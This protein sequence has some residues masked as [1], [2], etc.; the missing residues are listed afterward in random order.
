MKFNIITFG[1]K[2][3][4]YESN[5]MKETMLHHNFSFTPNFEDADIIIIN[6]CT[7]TNVADQKCLKQVRSIKRNHPEKILV[8]AG[9]SVQNKLPNYEDLDIAILLGNKDKT[10]I[11]DYINDYLNNHQKVVNHTTNRNLTFEDMQIKDYDHTRAFVKIQDGC[12][13]FCSYCIIPFVRGTTR[14][15]NFNQIIAEVKSLV[16]TN[17]KEIVLTGIHTGA[18]SDSGKDLSDVINALAE[19][20]GLERIRI[21]SIEITELNDKFLSTLKNCNKLCDNLHIPLQAGSDEVLLA[22]N[23]KYDLK[24]YEEKIKTIR[25]IRPGISITTDII[26]GFPGE[27]DEMFEHTYEFAQKIAFAKIHVFPYSKREGT[28]AAVMPQQING[29]IKKQRVAKLISLSES[30]EKAYFD[31]FKDQELEVLIEKVDK[32]QSFGHTSNYLY[33][34]INEILQVGNIYR[35]KI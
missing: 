9:C 3:N 1:C 31:Q 17:H 2:V 12:N 16:A 8:V 23:R 14:S 18:Y 34:T 7:V 32:N 35:R 29:N 27:T 10:K 21:S 13:N 15:K 33:V 6:T 11:A 22:M 20:D 25:S 19:I 24:Y 28:K 4:Q 5:M 30:L 26:V